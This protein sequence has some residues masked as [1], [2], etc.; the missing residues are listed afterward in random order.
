MTY[1][2]RYLV[3]AA[4]TIVVLAFGYWGIALP[5]R[6]SHLY[7]VA[8]RALPQVKTVE[9]METSFRAA[10]DLTAPFGQDET[11]VYYVQTIHGLIRSN[12]DRQVVKALMQEAEDVSARMRQRGRGFNYGAL[13]QALGGI[14]EMGY[15]ATADT[16]YHQKGID[17]LEKGLQYSPG[18]LQFLQGLLDFY[19]IT[20]DREHARDMAQRILSVWPDDKFALQA[21][22]EVGKQ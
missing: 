4:V 10:T 8:T 17:V 12:N 20:G 9:Q 1:L 6:R 2:W 22:S 7:I 21:L 15:L 13:L 11:V 5:L 3:A 14:Y 18:R 16:S 19:R